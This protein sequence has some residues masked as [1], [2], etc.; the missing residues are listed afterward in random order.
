MSGDDQCCVV[1]KCKR[2]PKRRLDHS[3]S[4]VVGGRGLSC[5]AQLPHHFRHLVARVT[6]AV[7]A[8]S[9]T[10]SRR[11]PEDLG[12]GRRGAQGV[13]VVVT[14][15]AASAGKDVLGEGAGL[16]VL[17]E[18]TVRHSCTGGGG[19]GRAQR[20]HLRARQLHTPGGCSRAVT[21]STAIA[22]SS[23][24]TARASAGSTTR[25]APRRCGHAREGTTPHPAAYGGAPS[26]APPPAVQRGRATRR[27]G[28]SQAAR[29]SSVSSTPPPTRLRSPDNRFRQRT[30]AS[31]SS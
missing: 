6:P 7:N 3:P 12:Q 25:P 14:E 16:V 5:L 28:T 24:S 30:G 8:G 10:G 27:Q 22:V 15:D 19:R 4:T 18:W 1:S 26:P 17:A 13:G 29:R 21:P 11:T 20:P 31:M 2:R 23:G 9:A